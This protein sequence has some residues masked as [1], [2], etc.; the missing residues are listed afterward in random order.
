ML[1]WKLA[2]FIEG[3]HYEDLPPETIR[4]ARLALL[5]W[6]RRYA[7]GERNQR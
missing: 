2:E 6:R 5:D 1:S 7:A 3:V 4:L